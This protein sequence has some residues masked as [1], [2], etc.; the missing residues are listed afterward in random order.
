MNEHDLKPLIEKLFYKPYDCLIT[1]DNLALLHKPSAVKT[2]QRDYVPQTSGPIDM[3]QVQVTYN[4]P[5][6]A[7]II[8]MLENGPTMTLD[9]E[10]NMETDFN[11]YGPEPSTL[12][13]SSIAEILYLNGDVSIVHPEV[14]EGMHADICAYLSSINYHRQ[15]SP[16]YTPPPQEDIDAFQ[17]LANIIEPIA[18]VYRNAGGGVSSIAQL[19]N[20]IRQTAT[21]NMVAAESMSEDNTNVRLSGLMGAFDLDCDLATRRI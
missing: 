8:A 17:K 16:H 20:M 2:L 6:E 11:V 13:V 3:P 15:R 4:N 9:M 18:R 19:M 12:T 5:N 10:N 21:G 14:I 7:A 1:V